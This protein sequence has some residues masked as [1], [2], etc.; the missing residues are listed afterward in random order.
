MCVRLICG[1]TDG[2]CGMEGAS[3]RV[4]G[5]RQVDSEQSVK[6][7]RLRVTGRSSSGRYRLIGALSESVSPR[8][9][10]PGRETRGMRKA[11]LDVSSRVGTIN[12]VS[13][14]A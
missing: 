8:N 4:V 9:I 2:S 6:R 1:V 3:G 11:R 7:G 13:G 12:A 14:A 10:R 5:L